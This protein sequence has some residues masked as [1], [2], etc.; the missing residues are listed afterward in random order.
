LKVLTKEKTLV[1][2]ETDDH[3]FE[4]GSRAVIVEAHPNF[5][6]LRLKG[7]HRSYLIEYAAIFSAAVK[8]SVQHDQAAAGRK[9]ARR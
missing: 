3:V 6:L 8:L 7:T 4:H 9:R 5:L 1:V 2:V